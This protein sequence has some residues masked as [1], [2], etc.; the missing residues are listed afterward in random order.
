MV[1]MCSFV[2]SGLSIV[3]ENSVAED[4]EIITLSW[5][6]HNHHS[7]DRYVSKFSERLCFL[8]QSAHAFHLNE[9]QDREPIWFRGRE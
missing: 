7:Y 2:G 1:Q 3:F 8:S 5:R 4:V 9:S 6:A